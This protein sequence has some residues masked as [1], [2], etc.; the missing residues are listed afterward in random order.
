[1]TFNDEENLQGVTFRRT[2]SDND[3]FFEKRG[4]VENGK[5]VTNQSVEPLTED[6]IN[7]L[8][9]IDDN[10]IV[11]AESLLSDDLLLLSL[12]NASEE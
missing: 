6:E 11:F 5:V 2:F 7:E 9:E 8:A 10:D 3:L 4:L 12:F 1:M